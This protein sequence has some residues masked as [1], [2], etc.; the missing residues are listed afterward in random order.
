MPNQNLSGMDS[1][2]QAESRRATRRP[3]R[4][5]G[6]SLAGA[7]TA[8]TCLSVLFGMSF[9][10]AACGQSGDADAEPAADADI[11]PAAADADESAGAEQDGSRPTVVASTTI[12]A[13]ITTAITCNGLVDVETLI[14][15]GA[16]PHVFEPS[17]ADRARLDEASLIVAN[18]LGLEESAIDTIEAAEG[19][20]T[21]V[22]E[23]ADHVE[24]IELGV[25]SDEHGDEE[26]GEHGD[27]HGDEEGGEHGDEEGGEHSDEEGD[28]HSDEEGD[29]H[30]EHGHD[31]DDPH[32]WFDPTR[33]SAALPALSDSLVEELGLDSA[34]IEVCVEEYQAELAEIDEEIVELTETIPV[35]GRILVTNHDSLGYFANRYGFEII[36][37]VIPSPSTLAESNP[38]DLESL[39]LDIEQ[40]GVPAIFTDEQSS[41]DDA[42][43]L[44]DRLD[45]DVAVV[46]LYTGSVGS[47]DTG[48]DTYTGLLRTNATLITEAL[49]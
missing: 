25:T 27:E 38:A 31:G 28:E 5:H 22:F 33:V 17:L 30:S 20:G 4:G 23:M 18:G 34:E 11:E 2:P 49:S 41:S 7:K 12:W 35:D 21:P 24:T 1:H 13:D 9:V 42:M 10:M 47:S 29:E 14:P 39:A 16:D 45:G 32:I 40:T 3:M 37:T 26:G 46:T 8:K 48:A 36:G 6:L 19:D 44:V 15:V 43:A